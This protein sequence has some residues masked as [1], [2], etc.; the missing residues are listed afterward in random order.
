MAAANFTKKLAELYCSADFAE[1]VHIELRYIS[2]I[3]I[4]LS[5]T[6]FLGNT[7]ILV[8]LRKE[9]SLN[10]PSKLLLQSLAA[11]DLCVGVIAHPLYIVD[12]ILL[13]KTGIFAAMQWISISQWTRYWALCLHPA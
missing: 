12:L 7:L 5:I 3:N 8:A 10:P 2:M 4:L 1:E 13:R 9:S 6:A 11:T